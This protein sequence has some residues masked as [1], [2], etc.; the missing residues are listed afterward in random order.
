MLSRELI[1]DTVFS[2]ANEINL[3]SNNNY[4]VMTN[5]S[6]NATNIKYPFFSMFQKVSH[7]II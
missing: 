3:L 1:V 2:P 6:H 5:D 4:Y 7:N